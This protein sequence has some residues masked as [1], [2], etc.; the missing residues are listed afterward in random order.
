MS[1]L[2]QNKAETL[3]LEHDIG[4]IGLLSG[5]HI[6]MP[7]E[8]PLLSRREP[9]R[10][11]LDAIAQEELDCAQSAYFLGDFADQDLLNLQ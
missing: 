4:V 3:G 11:E 2:T 8:I 5:M 6:P 9:T 1:R 10:A 7:F